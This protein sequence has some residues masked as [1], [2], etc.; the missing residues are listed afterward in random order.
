MDLAHKNSKTWHAEEIANQI[1]ME[2]HELKLTT[3]LGERAQLEESIVKLKKEEADLFNVKKTP[4]NAYQAEQDAAKEWEKTLLELTKMDEEAQGKTDGLSAAQLKFKEYLD[5]SAATINEKSVPGLNALLAIQVAHTDATE[6]DAKAAEELSKQMDAT[7]AS[8]E[9]VIDGLNKQIA[10]AKLHND[11]I[12][13]TPAQID[14]IKEATRQLALAEMERHA[15]LLQFEIDE[16][17]MSDAR[18][19]QLGA[20]LAVLYQQIAAQQTLAQTLNSGAIQQ[21]TADFTKN[22]T[23]SCD[24][25]NRSLTDA[26]LRGF[27]SGKGF[28]KNF[29]DTVSNMFDTLVLR[30][31]ISAIL[32]P[33]SGMVLGRDGGARLFRNRECGRSGRL[34]RNWL[35]VLRL[36]RKYYQRGGKRRRLSL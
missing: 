24:Q 7:A 35:L 18:R 29:V 19:A 26:L 23:K 30:P 17:N 2:Q 10:A 12:G 16:E 33:V 32:S 22:A 36:F 21:E 8:G 34:K 3:D 1:D 25:I 9:K 14:A 11:E 6:G 5:S 27:E 31:V 13:K 15:Q 20:E 28:A 4:G